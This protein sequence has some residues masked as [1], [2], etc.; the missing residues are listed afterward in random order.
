MP[1]KVTPA[2]RCERKLV[3]HFFSES[4]KLF[5]LILSNQS[6]KIVLQ[7]IILN[8]KNKSAMRHSINSIFV[9]QNILF[10]IYFLYLSACKFFYIGT[11]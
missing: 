8:I 10:S 9:I 5:Y 7:F 4:F 6:H 11:S 3:C 2:D 1:I